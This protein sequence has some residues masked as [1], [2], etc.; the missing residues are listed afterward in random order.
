MV[1]DSVWERKVEERIKN[2]KEKM[3]VMMMIV[4][5]GEIGVAVTPWLCVDADKG[6]D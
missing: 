6:R 2:I 1:Q 3:I 4:S 5:D